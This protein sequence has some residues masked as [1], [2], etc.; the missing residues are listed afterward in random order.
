MILHGSEGPVVPPEQ[1]RRLYDTPVRNGVPAEFLILE[2]ATHGD[3]RF[4]R[5]EMVDRILAFF[6]QNPIKNSL[7]VTTGNL[8]FRNSGNQPSF[9][10]RIKPSSCSKDITP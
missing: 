9:R 8:L 4:Y 10:E 5:D 6:Q 7:S 2:G 3:D 1:S